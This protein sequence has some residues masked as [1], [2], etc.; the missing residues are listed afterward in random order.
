MEKDKINRVLNNEASEQEAK[1]VAQWFGSVEGQLEVS[2][3][4]N[5][6]FEAMVPH[7]DAPE[8]GERVRVRNIKVRRLWWGVAAVVAIVLV[9]GAAAIAWQRP[10]QPKVSMQT[11]CANRGEQIQVVLQDGTHIH[12][13]AGSRLLFP[14]RFTSRNRNVVLVGE[15]YFE[16]A[17][18]KHRPF[19]VDLNGA[20]VEVLGTQFNVKAYENELVQV[21]LDEGHVV[22]H[23]A[24]QSVEMQAGERLSYDRRTCYSMLYRNTDTRMAS[25]WKEHR[26]EVNGMPMQ[27]LKTMLE[28][29]YDVDINI[30]DA[31]CYEYSYSLVVKSNKLENVLKSMS[32]VSLICYQYDDEKGI[33]TISTKQ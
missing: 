16:V 22:F 31:K 2:N 32:L 25:A 13:N 5:D 28:R 24:K 12:L 9:L 33:V 7:F 6:D 30:R 20:S 3:M 10:M 8:H 19:V 29:D 18:N 21:N 15:A 17:K 23:G 4:L 1:E 11:V 14:S 27:E 26:L